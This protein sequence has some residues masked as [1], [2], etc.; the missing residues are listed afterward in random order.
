[1]DTPQKIV[2]VGG[3][4][5]I[6]TKITEALLAEGHSVLV[7]DMVRPR[8]SHDRLSFVVSDAMRQGIDPRVFTDAYGVINL[9]G[10][11]IG[12][13]WTSAYKQLIRESRIATTR[14]I[15]DALSASSP[16]PAVLISAS[17][18]GYY[19]DGGT[20][21]LRED[22]A[23]GTDYLAR[24]CFDWEREAARA[25]SLGMRVVSIRTANVL[26]RGGLLDT[27][28]PLFRKGLGGYF[29]S[30]SQYMPWV[31]VS[32]IV[33][34][35]IFALKHP[36]SGAYNTGA[37]DTPTQK[38]LFK[39]YGRSIHSRFL[40]RIPAFAARLVLGDFAEALLFGQNTLS[41]KL[42]HVGYVYGF[43][44]LDIALSNLD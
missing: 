15:V 10:A 44:V 25:E 29:G 18:V 13:R 33:A 9:A 7:L 5:F 39:T 28:R 14:H 31:H 24:L 43:S 11:T 40:W 30:G 37:G 41:D 2:I 26:G 38:E 34:I 27:L 4:G 1:M 19:G 36:L 35:Y 17:A 8:L 23:A 32:D 12:K 20:T 42:K 6:G 22:A 21:I 3:S 16:V